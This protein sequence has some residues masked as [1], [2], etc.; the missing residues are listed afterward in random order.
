MVFLYVFD[1]EV[2]VRAV[3]GMT[4]TVCTTSYEYEC[5]DSDDV[6]LVSISPDYLLKTN[7]Y[8]VMRIFTS[9]YFKNIVRGF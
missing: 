6:L 4:H 8:D 2:V 9:I 5:T 3:G 7:T 1:D